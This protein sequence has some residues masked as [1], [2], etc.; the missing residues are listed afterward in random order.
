MT[1]QSVQCRLANTHCR[2]RCTP[3][4]YAVK[5]NICTLFNALSSSSPYNHLFP[6]PPLFSLL[7][8]PPPLPRHA[9]CQD[10]LA[11]IPVL[12]NTTAIAREISGTLQCGSTPGDAPKGVPHLQNHNPGTQEDRVCHILAHAVAGTLFSWLRVHAVH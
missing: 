1:C 11:V 3:P 2:E 4:L 10:L 12:H 8:P 6:S 5:C 9:V 7:S